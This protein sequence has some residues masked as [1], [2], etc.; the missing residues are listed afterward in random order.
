[1]LEMHDSVIG[2]LFSKNLLYT[3]FNVWRRYLLHKGKLI[4]ALELLSFG[5]KNIFEHVSVS[6]GRYGACH[7]VIACDLFENQRP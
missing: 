3:E 2:K 7:R 5:Y 4:Q 1:M 6:P